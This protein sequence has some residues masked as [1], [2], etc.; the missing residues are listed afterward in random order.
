M[1]TYHY[2]WL[3]VHQ[4]R[5]E[6]WLRERLRDGFDIHHLDGDHYNDDPSN[7]ALV[8]ATDHMRLH[9]LSMNRLLVKGRN[10]RSPDLGPIAYDMKSTARSWAD[11]GRLLKPDSEQP[12]AWA[13]GTAKRYADENS[14]PFPKPGSN[15]PH[16]SLKMIAA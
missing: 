5:N 7:L 6:E 9:G 16:V 10:G 3:S 1:Q 14:L 13:R 2:A 8:E 15:I 4:N 11:I 12:A